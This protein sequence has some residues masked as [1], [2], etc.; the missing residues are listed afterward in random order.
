MGALVGCLVIA[1]ALVLMAVDY[2]G[3]IKK[4]LKRIADAYSNYDPEKDPNF[5]K[6]DENEECGPPDPN[7]T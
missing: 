1:V 4:D 7:V 5:P 6:E 3:P 2:L